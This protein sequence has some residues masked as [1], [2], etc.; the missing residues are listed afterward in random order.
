MIKMIKG[1]DIQY[2]IPNCKNVWERMGY[3]EA[4]VDEKTTIK[5]ELDALGVDYH[6]QLGLTKLKKLLETSK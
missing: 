4:T 1:E 5:A 6:P 3:T 2:C